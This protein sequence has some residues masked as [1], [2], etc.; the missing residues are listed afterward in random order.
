M[1][2]NGKLLVEALPLN[3]LYTVYNKHRRL[4]VF[5]KKGRSCVRCGREGVLLLVTQETKGKQRKLHIDLY[6][7]DFILVTV[8]H[9]VAKSIGRKAGW[10][11][12]RIESI[13]NKQ[14]MCSPCNSKKGDSVFQLDKIPTPPLRS[15]YGAIWRLLEN[16]NIF[17]KEIAK[18]T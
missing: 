13:D 18:N 9:I 4:K 16:N 7:R 17:N 11:R 1:I 8:D 3:D 14:T 2:L 15:E 6:T 5:A 10:S 12:A